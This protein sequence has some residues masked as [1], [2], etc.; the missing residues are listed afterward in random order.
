MYAHS[1]YAELNR[2]L[3]KIAKL[4]WQD[5]HKILVKHLPPGV[6]LTVI[7]DSCHSGTA[8]DLPYVYNETGCIE[9]PGM[10]MRLT[11]C[12]QG[13]SIAD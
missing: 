12:Y 7:F 2:M 3:V 6:R 4:P 8:M 9:S 10:S 5:L 11:S 1:S 13:S